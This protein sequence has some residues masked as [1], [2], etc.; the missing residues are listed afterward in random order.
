[1]MLFLARFTCPMA[2]YKHITLNTSHLNIV[3]CMIALLYDFYKLWSVNILTLIFQY[4]LHIRWPIL[5][6]W[7]SNNRSP[8]RASLHHESHTYC[9]RI[10]AVNAT[11]RDASFIYMLIYIYQC[12]YV[13]IK[14][15]KIQIPH[16]TFNTSD[17]LH[18]VI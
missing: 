5:V 14:G 10:T 1:M 3:I 12:Q 4:D 7:H 2:L 6:M 13:M 8:S 17:S 9:A 18:A 15:L 11:P 16:S